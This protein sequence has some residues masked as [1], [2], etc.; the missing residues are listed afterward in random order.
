MKKN[1]KKTLLEW[2]QQNLKKLKQ[3]IS[4]AKKEA[5]NQIKEKKQK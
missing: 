5:E 3:Q 4:E 1:N 2:E